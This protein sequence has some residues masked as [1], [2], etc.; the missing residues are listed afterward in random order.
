M[1][2]DSPRKAAKA[3]PHAPA[4]RRVAASGDSTGWNQQKDNHSAVGNAF[5]THV[6]LHEP[7]LSAKWGLVWDEVP[8]EHACDVDIH[9]VSAGYL[10]DHHP[11]AAGVN[12]GQLLHYNTAEAYW[13]GLVQTVAKRF[14]DSERRETTV[15]VRPCAPVRARARPCA[16]VRAPAHQTLPHLSGPRIV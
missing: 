2:R 10:A 14:A 6:S 4:I 12:K 3:N 7:A 15:R 13:G 5:L 9:A 16:P 1:G 8:E 11:Q